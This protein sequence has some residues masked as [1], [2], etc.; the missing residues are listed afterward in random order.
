MS[1]YLK[2][3]WNS[4]SDTHAGFGRLLFKMRPLLPLRRSPA[5]PGRPLCKRGSAL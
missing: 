1:S 4:S 2:G 3:L 5:C